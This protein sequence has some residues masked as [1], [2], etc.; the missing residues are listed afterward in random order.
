MVGG[1][2]QIP[3]AYGE[4]LANLPVNLKAGL[5]RIGFPLIPVHDR[6]ALVVGLVG[7]E[8]PLSDKGCELRIDHVKRNRPRRTGGRSGLCERRRASSK[9]CTVQQPGA[10]SHVPGSWQPG[11]VQRALGTGNKK[12]RERISVVKDSIPCAN[13]RFRIRRV[14]DPDSRLDAALISVDEESQTR[15]DVIS[16]PVVQSELRRD[17]PL[18]LSEKPPVAVVQGNIKVLGLVRPKSILPSHPGLRKCPGKV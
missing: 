10:G 11:N 2:K 13:D 5:F 7:W 12:E 17:P 18:I 14:G 9:K 3:S 4:P 16:R 1:H 6:P 15:F 8:G